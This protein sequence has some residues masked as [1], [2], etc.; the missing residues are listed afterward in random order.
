MTAARFTPAG[1]IRRYC[2]GR[3][4]P[5]AMHP[6]GIDDRKAEWFR[7]ALVDQARDELGGPVR[8]LDYTVNVAPDQLLPPGWLYVLATAEIAP[9]RGP[10]GGHVVDAELTGV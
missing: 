3:S 1:P 5:R 7:A 8:V 6:D 9:L 4:I 2:L 10:F